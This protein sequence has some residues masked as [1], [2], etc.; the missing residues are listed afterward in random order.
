MLLQCGIDGQC[1]VQCIGPGGENMKRWA[2]SHARP[3]GPVVLA[4][5]AGA[6]S[7][8][9]HAGSAYIAAL[10]VDETGED[11]WTPTL[12]QPATATADSPHGDIVITSTQAP[13]TGR[14]AR[15]IVNRETGGMLI[16]LE[17]VAFALAA[18]KGAWPWWGV[19]RGVSDD[20]TTLLPEG[21]D[22]WVSDGGH[23][24]WGH[25]MRSLLLRPQ[26]IPR[27]L[28]MREHSIAA[29]RAVAGLLRS[30]L[31]LDADGA[32]PQAG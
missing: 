17:S 20:L 7:P 10:V 19:V 3:D 28:T 9:C 16:D 24:R 27:V 23:T 2:T 12:T 8:L 25:V 31:Q 1:D 6:L 15:Q 13:I 11:S 5:L 14:L 30:M 21:V 18:Q 32:V 26:L 29:M 4:G 22:E